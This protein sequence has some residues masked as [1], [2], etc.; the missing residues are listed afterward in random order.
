MINFIKGIIVGVYNIIP[1]LSGSAILVAFNLYEKCLKAISDF[2][3]KPKQS[4]ILLFPIASG[5]IIGTYLFSNI[6]VYLLNNYPLKTY[7][8]FTILILTTIPHLFKESIKYGFKAKYLIPFFITF[9]IGILFVFL[10][11]KNLNY[12]INY[13]FLSILKY[14]FIG[15]I[16]SISTVIPGISSTVLLS[17]LNLYGIYIYSISTLNLF[18][19]FP[20]F[21]GFIITT[22][23]ISKLINF[24]LKKYYSYTYFAI[25]GFCLSTTLCFIKVII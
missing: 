5:I 12:T 19:L 8:I 10:D 9:L 20:I 13:S 15:I 17:I 3:K 16:L 23:F 21:I 4:F 7:T 11:I 25:L 14:L 1:G 24:L 22:F 2:F 18:I 6:I